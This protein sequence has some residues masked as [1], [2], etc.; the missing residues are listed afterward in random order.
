VAT[1]GPQLP[2]RPRKAGPSASGGDTVDAVIASPNS[3]E[4]EEEEEEGETAP[5]ALKVQ[6]MRVYLAALAELY[7]AQVSMVLHK[8]PNF[9]GAALKRLITGLSRTQARKR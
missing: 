2:T 3:L 7:S 5:K 1:E 4:E 9:R 8:H 6:T